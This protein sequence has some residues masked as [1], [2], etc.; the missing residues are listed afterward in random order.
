MNMNKLAVGFAVV[1]V[2]AVATGSAEA[3]EINF[4]ESF[5][6]SV[7]GT[8]IDTNSDGRPAALAITEGISNLGP[9]TR[10][11]VNEFAP[12]ASV[13]CP[14]GK[15]GS[16]LV[17]GRLVVR[18][19]KKKGD[20]FFVKSSSGTLCFDPTTGISTGSQVGDIIGG[21]GRFDGATGSVEIN[22]TAT[23]LVA[24]PAGRQFNSVIGTL[25][26]TIITP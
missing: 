25:T 26:G 3:K 23:R 17:M 8:Q 7:V 22:F 5:S 11:A 4:E 19:D 6:G 2:M 20:L 18:L 15:V 14:S 12:S 10:Q 16:T 24:D 1:L 13:P 21:T 9:T